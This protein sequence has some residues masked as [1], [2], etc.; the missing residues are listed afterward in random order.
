MP[1]EGMY[2]RPAGVERPCG[3]GKL[4]TRIMKSNNAV[5]TPTL[6]GISNCEYK[7]NAVL[8]AQRS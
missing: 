6:G 1:A 7:G 3:C 8:N 4:G 5:I 2:Q